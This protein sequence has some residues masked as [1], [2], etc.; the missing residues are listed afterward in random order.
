M[1][2]NSMRSTPRG[3]SFARTSFALLLRGFRLTAFGPFHF[4]ARGR[5]IWAEVDRMKS[6]ALITA[7]LYLAVF[8]HTVIGKIEKIDKDQLL[9]KTQDG[10]V[11]L[12][13]DER[14]IVRKSKGRNDLSALAPGDEIRAS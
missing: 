14:T 7:F 10:I 1:R 9:I 8:G 11:T 3:G 2:G 4:D 5:S 12:H 13:V 6:C